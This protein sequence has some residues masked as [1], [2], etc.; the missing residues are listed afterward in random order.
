MERFEAAGVA[1]AP[2]YEIPDFVADPHVAARGIL[3]P[4]HDADIGTYP[5][6]APVPRLS[7]TPG[8]VRAPGPKLGQHSEAIISDWLG[9]DREELDALKRD[10]VIEA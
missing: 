5:M 8:R 7:A 6:H 9:L 10:R 4:I 3:L 2:I 1:G